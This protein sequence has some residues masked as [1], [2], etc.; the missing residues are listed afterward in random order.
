MAGVGVVGAGVSAVGSC[1]RPM[2]RTGSVITGTTG[3]SFSSSVATFGLILLQYED[4]R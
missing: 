1:S 4:R 3:V 2:R